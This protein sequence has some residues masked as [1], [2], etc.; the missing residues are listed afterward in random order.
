[1]S[2][3]ESVSYF[4]RHKKKYTCSVFFR[5]RQRVEICIDIVP[6]TN[7]H[8]ARVASAD[9]SFRDMEPFF[10]AALTDED[11]LCRALRRC[12][13]SYTGMGYFVSDFVRAGEVL[14]FHPKYP[15][16]AMP[17]LYDA[18]TPEMELPP[19]SE[20]ALRE[21]SAWVTVGSHSV[22]IR[23]TETGGEVSVTPCGLE[24]DPEGSTTLVF[25]DTDAIAIRRDAGLEEQV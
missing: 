14:V 12:K 2:T 4:V 24:A 19:E 6:T 18:K 15:E 3:W 22:Y 7:T 13:V 10:L 11:L 1:M 16:W 9:T 23:R 17:H 5:A 8:R 25:Y 20:S 21:G